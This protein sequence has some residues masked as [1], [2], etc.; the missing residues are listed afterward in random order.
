M[1]ATVDAKDLRQG[2]ARAKRAASSSNT[3][4][5]VLRSL[6]V[7]AIGPDWLRL[8]GTDLDRVAMVD[9]PAVVSDPAGTA[10]LPIALAQKVIKG[11]GPIELRSATDA[12]ILENGARYELAA[13]FPDEFPDV[14]HLAR[15]KG[16]GHPASRGTVP[17]EVLEYVFNATSTDP[18]R[19]ML[20]GVCVRGR[21]VVA[22]DSYRLSIVDMGADVFPEL[23]ASEPQRNHPILPR[24]FVADLLATK[25]AQFALE[26]EGWEVRCAV[27]GQYPE[28]WGAVLCDASFPDPLSVVKWDVEPLFGFVRPA[29]EQALE[30]VRA[31]VADNTT[32][33]IV[34]KDDAG[35]RLTVV[36]Q[37]AGNA[38]AVVAGEWQASAIDSVALNPG[39]LVDLLDGRGATQMSF[40]ENPG[41][42]PVCLTDEVAGYRAARL[43]MPVRIS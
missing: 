33:V 43:L 23:E 28:R 11:T 35:L 15:A 8:T 29:F 20:N 1:Q 36:N 5:A 14:E 30:K 22:T 21:Y 34:H 16:A 17:R 25:A 12:V 26:I 31:M 19:P 13:S 32:P 18:A 4:M 40:A 10:L 39:F 3:A 7:E 2:I 38:E 41:R 37:Q 42:G 9:I 6:R 24:T 27:T